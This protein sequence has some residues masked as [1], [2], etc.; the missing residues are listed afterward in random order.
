MVEGSGE[1]LAKSIERANWTNVDD[2]VRE[3]CTIGIE[4]GW[5]VVE[6]RMI[7]ENVIEKASG[8]GYSERRSDVDVHD[9]DVR[10]GGMK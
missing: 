2:D 10:W 3:Y 8:A 1:E 9:D 6:V 4:V 7:G 5:V